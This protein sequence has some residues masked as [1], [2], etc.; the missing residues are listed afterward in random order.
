ML[1]MVVYALIRISEDLLQSYTNQT[2][3][4]RPH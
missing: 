3:R 4:G 1:E 2:A